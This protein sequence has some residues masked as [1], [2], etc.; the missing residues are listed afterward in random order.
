MIVLLCIAGIFI[1]ASIYYYFKAEGL[2]QQLLAVRKELKNTKKESK[3][4][5]DAFAVMARKSEDTL[6]HRVKLASDA[7]ASHEVIDL[8]S[9][10]VNN[11]AT[12]FSA[13]IKGNGEMH[14]VTQKCF[15]TYHKGSF[16]KF[17][18]YIGTL[19]THIKR[20]WGNNN[21]TGLITFSEAIVFHIE[22]TLEKAS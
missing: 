9:P 13:T 20:A 7:G 21:L 4:L 15:E 6:K 22:S 10:F 2:H 8:F 16:R 11:Y 1:A 14:K 5:V 19:D 17:T 12:I 18:G 3:A